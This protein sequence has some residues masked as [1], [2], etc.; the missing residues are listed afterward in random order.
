MADM[1]EELFKVNDAKFVKEEVDG[2]NGLLKAFSKDHIE[3]DQCIR[4]L[5]SGLIDAF[6]KRA[7]S[8]DQMIRIFGDSSS[9]NVQSSLERV[10]LSRDYCQEMLTMLNMFEI[11]CEGVENATKAYYDKLKTSYTNQYGEGKEE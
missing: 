10:K 8:C 6:R 5:S 1:S 9:D 11:G 4:K 7:A 2:I 3:E